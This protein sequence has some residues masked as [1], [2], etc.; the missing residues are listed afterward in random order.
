MSLSWSV[1]SHFQHVSP[2]SISESVMENPLLMN[3]ANW[4]WKHTYP[5]KVVLQT[6]EP[7]RIER[8]SQN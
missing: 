3:L 4:I 7:C 1:R 2:L 6:T 5:S 8:Q